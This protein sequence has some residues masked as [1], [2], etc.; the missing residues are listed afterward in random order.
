MRKRI[1]ISGVISLAA[2]LFLFVTPGNAQNISNNTIGISPA[3]SNIQLSPGQTTISVAAKI[4]NLTSTP[5][6]ISLRARDFGALNES[7]TAGFYGSGYNPSTNPHA[8]Q[9]VM[10][11]SPSTVF[12]LAHDSQTV[13]VNL[14]NLNTLAA[15][16]HFGAALFT[17]GS[18]VAVPTNT[19][20]AIRSSLASLIFLTTATGGTQHVTLLPF[21]IAP[22]RFSLPSTTYVGF[23]N[24]GNTQSA[25]QGQLTLYGPSG[26]IVSTEVLNPG[27]GLVLPSSSRVLPVMLPLPS[28]L[29]TMPGSYRMELQY[30]DGLQ[31]TFTIVN[32]HFYYLNPVILALVLLVCIILLYLWGKGYISV[33]NTIWNLRRILRHIKKRKKQEPETPPKAKRPPPLIQG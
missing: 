10:S 26:R 4:T 8:L 2:A 21:H 22:I 20:V 5:L 17:P 6:S 28:G 31:S 25:P 11:F 18:A 30:R 19:N 29:F 33:Q 9:N 13:A 27:S 7:G 32:Q 12:L 3:L 15:G 1:V 23:H 16:G 14:K 24:S